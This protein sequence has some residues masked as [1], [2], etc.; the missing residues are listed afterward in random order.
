MDREARLIRQREAN[1]RYRANHRDKELQRFR[2]YRLGHL[3][4]RA[5]YQREWRRT[6]PEQAA[7]LDAAQVANAKARHVGQPGRIRGADVLAL[8]KRRPLCV[9]C[10]QGRGVDHIIAFVDGGAN[11][12][13]NLQTMCKPCN[14]A[15][16][17]A[18]R[19]KR[20]PLFCQRGHPMSGDNL[21]TSPN[22]RGVRQCRSCNR[23]RDR[24]RKR[25]GHATATVVPMS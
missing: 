25:R 10:G 6:H 11:E 3:D 24:R 19:W 7:A 15:K 16:D 12:V 17:Y 2:D 5:A 9:T 13:A 1:A 4:E 8:W 20:R 18:E 23:L 14:S 21:W 22:A